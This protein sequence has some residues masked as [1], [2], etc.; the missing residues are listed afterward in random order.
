MHGS[1]S[2]K[3]LK[4]HRTKGKNQSLWDAAKAMWRSKC[5]ELLTLEK[6]ERSKNNFKKR[7]E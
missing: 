3:N 4:I 7:A 6:K 2:V 5:T 1:K